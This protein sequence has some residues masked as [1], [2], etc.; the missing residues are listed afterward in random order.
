MTGQ[1]PCVAGH[2]RLTENRGAYSRR[3]LSVPAQGEAKLKPIHD[4]NSRRRRVLIDNSLLMDDPIPFEA[5]QL[6]LGR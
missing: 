6:K 1:D 4:G 5:Q 3:S 2:C